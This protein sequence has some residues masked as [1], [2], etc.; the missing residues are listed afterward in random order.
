MTDQV[1]TI[2]SGR[3]GTK[4]MATILSTVYQH[5]FHEYDQIVAERRKTFFDPNFKGPLLRAKIARYRKLNIFHDSDNCNTVFIHHLCA[6][7]PK[8]KILL[9]VGSLKSFVRAH[10]IWGIMGR[11]DKNLH[12][13]MM[14][15]G[16]WR[17]WPIVV[18]LAWLW[19]KR[20][21]EAIKR[22][23]NSRLLVFRTTDIA[24]TIDKIF[25][26][27]EK[28][29]NDKAIKLSKMHHNALQCNGKQRLDAEREINKHMG[30]IEEVV[31]PMN[32]IIQ[33]AL[34]LSR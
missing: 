31:A 10:Y 33:N 22:S 4:S 34:R 21:T 29:L 25:K 12:T 17:N 30:R 18:R 27:I 5:S 24:K 16:G 2:G 15:P 23:D 6:A 20:N 14:P 32:G 11:S 19:A 9:P 28:P 13:R 26:F 3:N 8:A 1:F 7:F